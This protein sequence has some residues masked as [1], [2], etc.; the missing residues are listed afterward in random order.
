MVIFTAFFSHLIKHLIGRERRVQI[1]CCIAVV[2]G[3]LEKQVYKTN[4]D[5]NASPV[6]VYS[7]PVNPALRAHA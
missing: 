1:E 6:H 2:A 3:L 7:S 5:L 4:I